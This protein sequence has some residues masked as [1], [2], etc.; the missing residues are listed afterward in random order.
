M[1]IVSSESF[2]RSEI[3]AK[4]KS[5]TFVAQQSRRGS[6]AVLERL[7]HHVL[8]RTSREFPAN[9]KVLPGL[10][11]TIRC[12]HL[13]ADRCGLHPP[14]PHFPQTSRRVRENRRRQSS[15]CGTFPRDV[16]GGIAPR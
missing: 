5:A 10:L 13:I 15:S 6:F 16:Q 7:R 2:R 11:V 14:P 12:L 9:W 1:A 4:A 3:C 8:W